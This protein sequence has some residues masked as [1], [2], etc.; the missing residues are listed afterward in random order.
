MPHYRVRQHAGTRNRPRKRC[1]TATAKK[2]KASHPGLY[3]RA[4]PGASVP[5]KKHLGT[6]GA[7]VL[8]SAAPV[9]HN[10][11]TAIQGD[12]YCIAVLLHLSICC[13]GVTKA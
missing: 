12:T 10:K 6:A 7:E 2:K 8:I 9:A 3:G 13:C 11:P 4:S 1:T 5:A